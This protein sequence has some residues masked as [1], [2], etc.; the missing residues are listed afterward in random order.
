MLLMFT[1]MPEEFIPEMY[2]KE[3]KK[4]RK[5]LEK[6]IPTD[7]AILFPN[8]DFTRLNPESQKLLE[9][10]SHRVEKEDPEAELLFL[11]ILAYNKEQYS[12]EKLTDQD[13]VLLDAL[14][15]KVENKK[16]NL[17]QTLLV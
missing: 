16:E 12:K 9:E 10:I 4:A 1:H 5:E 2:T 7:L 13:I 14:E 8:T 15:K 17:K 3:H 6:H 11:K